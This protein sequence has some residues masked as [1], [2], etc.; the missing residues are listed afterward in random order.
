MRVIAFDTE[1]CLFRPGVMAPELVCV[2]WQSP[3][4]DA[5][6]RHANDVRP[7][8]VD[9]LGDPNVLL[10]GA[11]VAYDMAVIAAAFP[12]LVPAIFAAY[13]ADRVT[14]IQLRQKLLDI[15]AGCYRG[16]L[17]DGNKWIKY[18]YSLDAI[19][20]RLCGRSLEKDTWRLRYGEF[21]NVPLEQWPEGART[22]PLEDARA[23]LDTYLAQEPHAAEYLADQYRQARAAWWLHLASAWGLRTRAAGVAKLKA[24]T[25]A[26][27]DLVRDRLIAAGLVRKDGSRDTKVAA[28]YMQ[29]ACAAAGLPVRATDG[30]GV[31]LDSD[32]CKATDDPTLKDYAKLSELGSVLNKDI[33]ALEAGVTYP[34]HTRFDLAETGRTT[35][36][37]PNV[38]NWR[39][40]PGIREA[41]TPR[42]GYVYAQADYNGLEL[43]TLAQS[44]LKLV[45]RSALAEAL[46][47]GRDP[48]LALGAQIL[49]ISYQEAKEN[50]KRADVDAAR[51]T[52]KVANFGFPGGLGIEKLRLFAKK[53]YKV[54]LSE[55][56]ARQLKAQWLERWP[57]MVDYFRH[58]NE[59]TDQNYGATIKHLF[60]GR[61]RGGASYTAACNSYFQGLGSDATKHAG[62]LISAACYTQPRS[63]LFG[64]RI[65]NYVH[66]EFI[67]E[68]RDLPTAHE[69]A[70]ELARLMIAGAS[71]FLP[72]VPPTTEPLLM[73]FWSKDAKP[74]FDSSGRL[75][76]WSG[77]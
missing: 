46:N 60:S 45:G 34:V 77:T 75:I 27:A 25:E 49:G 37:K 55:D 32:A 72:D 24:E 59:I 3:G 39:R 64:S 23:T 48:H 47:S 42:A 22:Y 16:R 10:V 62:F 50:K 40:L 66:D 44:C 20:R 43:R 73:R 29:N 13:E 35:S 30:G 58:V 38:Q 4:T 53:T 71:A 17:G 1:T 2:T 74:V 61:I 26:A 65:V 6:I 67:V 7:L 15:A 54:D 41:F 31:S 76:P 19:T 9:W 5:R 14:D 21:R 70:H 11:N 63:P 56:R 12:E 18:D 36:S 8:L 68:T 33:P 69:A 52:A 57:E 51:Q 28:L